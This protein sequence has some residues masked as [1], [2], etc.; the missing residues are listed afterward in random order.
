MYIPSTRCWSPI[1]YSFLPL[2][3]HSLSGNTF[4]RTGP[5]V[6]TDPCDGGQLIGG[7]GGG[8]GGSGSVGGVGIVSAGRVAL[9]PR[10]GFATVDRPPD[11]H[12]VI[13]PTLAR[14]LADRTTS[15]NHL[16]SSP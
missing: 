14:E 16:A 15:Q 13:V 2:F 7:D 12:G 4:S 1:C 11:M 3:K 6:P 9:S 5:P 10:K 8:G